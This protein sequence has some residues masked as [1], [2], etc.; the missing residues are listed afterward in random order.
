MGVDSKKINISSIFVNLVI[1][2]EYYFF[3]VVPFPASVQKFFTYKNKIG[4]LFF[5]ILAYLS[6]RILNSNKQKVG[7]FNNYVIL[8]LCLIFI[9]VI[10]CINKYEF[11]KSEL[12][13]PLVAFIS[14]LWFVPL[15]LYLRNH[16]GY[17][18]MSLTYT[19]IIAGIIVLIQ[20]IYFFISQNVFLHVYEI[21]QPG[22]FPVRNGLLRI[23]YLGTV[24]SL[25]CV[26]SIGIL[27]SERSKHKKLHITNCIITFLYFLL[28]SQTR[29]YIFCLTLVVVILFIKKNFKL[30]SNS[31]LKLFLFTICFVFVYFFVLR[32]YAY[33]IIRPLLNG[34]YQ[35]DG[36]YY[37][38]ID[39]I[40]Y[41]FNTIKENTFLG[42]GILEP[43][44]FTDN[45][46]TFHGPTGHAVMTDVGLL[47]SVARL[48]IPILIWYI[49]LLFKLYWL[50]HI[51]N[52]FLLTS[53]FY[54]ILFTSVSL[55]V[56][57]P[58]RIF[59]LSTSLAIFNYVFTEKG[60]DSMDE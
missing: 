23:T 59:F 8:F 24:M 17:F 53:I 36:S 52:N 25:S 19:N 39:A 9:S 32:D 14:I 57:D 6:V 3:Y 34:S 7:I 47:G 4:L 44:R 41:F 11:A 29:M 12:I 45:Y 60:K 15:S 30:T 5:I 43:G 42:L 50:Q 49:F 31:L 10:Y 37:A 22:I 26:V 55:I 33:D 35:Y 38:R 21:Y 58:Q 46:A 13:V 18:V 1:L 16:M 27:F 51:S 56:L 54:F 28:V 40:S 48:G 20:G 2:C